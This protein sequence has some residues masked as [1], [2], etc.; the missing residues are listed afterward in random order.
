MCFKAEPNEGFITET[1]TG[2]CCFG[3]V[4]FKYVGNDFLSLTRA[5]LQHKERH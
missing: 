1:V 5:H 3:G 2:K 4:H